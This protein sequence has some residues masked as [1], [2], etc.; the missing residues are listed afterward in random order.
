MAS[1][2]HAWWS[3]CWCE[4]GQHY[5]WQWLVACRNQP[6]TPTN[7]YLSTFR[8]L[9]TYFNEDSN[10]FQTFSFKQIHFEMAY[11]KW[12]QLSCS[13]GVLNK[14]QRYLLHLRNSQINASWC[15][16][17]WKCWFPS[18]ALLPFGAEFL[19]KPITRISI[20]DKMSHRKIWRSLEAGDFCLYL[21]DLSDIWQI[22]RHYFCVPTRE[23]PE[24]CN[25]PKY[26]K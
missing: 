8:L 23:I 25:N 16:H 3:G 2:F 12:R 26:Q 1:T 15:N 21:C 19:F 5:F 18:L 17:R 4:I 24:R 20:T 22:H 14:L 11:T 7:F 13:L 6:I 10:K 9:W